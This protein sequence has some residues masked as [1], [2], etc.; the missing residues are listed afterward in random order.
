ME[1]ALA[2]RKRLF[3]GQSTDVYRLLNAEGDGIPGVVMD[4]YGDFGVAWGKTSNQEAV[5]DVIYRAAR[6]AG[7]EM[8]T[9]CGLSFSRRGSRSHSAPTLAHRSARCL[10]SSSPPKLIAAAVSS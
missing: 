4:R 1:K 8:K 10:I 6:D 2:V 5:G 3:K 9:Q 7:R